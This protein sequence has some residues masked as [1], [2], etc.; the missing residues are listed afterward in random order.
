VAQYIIFLWFD[1]FN[2]FS[3]ISLL[4]LKSLLGRIWFLFSH[5]VRQG[6]TGSR[7]W[8]HSWFIDSVVPCHVSTIKSWNLKQ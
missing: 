2:F 4:S 6:M 1:P 8:L 5:S 7:M 3:A